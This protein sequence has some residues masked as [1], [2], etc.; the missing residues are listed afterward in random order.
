MKIRSEEVAFSIPTDSH[1]GVTK[2]FSILRKHLT[3]YLKYCASA[4]SLPSARRRLWQQH[5]RTNILFA[6]N[7]YFFLPIVHL[8]VFPSRAASF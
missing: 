6:G 1:S 2:V 4:L 7:L 3:K 8:I 5:Y